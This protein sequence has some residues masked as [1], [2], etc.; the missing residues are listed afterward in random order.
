MLGSH[1]EAH[2]KLW[3]TYIKT[4]LLSHLGNLG[5]STFFISVL[6]HPKSPDT[7]SSTKALLVYNR[8]YIPSPKIRTVIFIKHIFPCVHSKIW[9]FKKRSLLCFLSL[10][11][12]CNSKYPKFDLLIFILKFNFWTCISFLLGVLP[13]FQLVAWA[14]NLVVILDSSLFF[15]SYRQWVIKSRTFYLYHLFYTHY[16][17]SSLLPLFLEQVSSHWNYLNRHSQWFFLYLI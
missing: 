1:T 16:F 10:P 8:K 14:R 2:N 13:P 6:E 11:H 3:L 9:M 5:V 12:I 17:F 15:T 4:D 7:D